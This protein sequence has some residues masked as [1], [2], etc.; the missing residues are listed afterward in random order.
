MDRDELRE[1]IAGII[2]DFFVSYSGTL[3]LAGLKMLIGA[4]I[5]AIRD[6]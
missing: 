1:I 4:I 2:N 6:A 3:T 5:E